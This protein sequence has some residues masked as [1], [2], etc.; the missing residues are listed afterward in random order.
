M[1][2]LLEV[3]LNDVLVG[4]LVLAAGDRIIFTFT[5]SYINDKN[6]PTLSQSFLN[7]HGDVIADVKSTHTKL[8]PFFSNLL[9]EGH[10]RK[11]LA[12]QGSVNPAREYKLIELLGDDLPGAVKIKP[13]D[14]IVNVTDKII[15]ND[16]NKHLFHFSLAGIQ[17]KFSALM[18]AAGG[19]TIPTSGVGGDWIVKLP[20]QNFPN[21]PEN[22]FSMLSLAQKT[23][24]NVPEFKL[25]NLKDVSGL[26]DL[27]VLAGQKALAIKRFDRVNG[28]RIHIEDFAQVYGLFPESKYEKAS[29]NNIAHVIWRLTGEAALKDFIRRLTFTVMIGNGDMHLKNWSLIYQDGRTAELAPA[30]DFVSTIPYIPNDKLA[31]T[32]GSTKDMSS[33]NM[34]EFEKLAKKAQVPKSI[35]VETAKETALTV[36]EAWESNK[37]AYPLSSEISE[38]INQ[39]ILDAFNGV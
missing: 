17:L 3:S 30:Y 14:G 34:L 12:E 4:K 7:Q 18:E 19:L 20:A 16:S 2:D 13:L 36:R 22:E 26:P 38:R 37:L 31:L 8:P 11:Y 35:V 39:Y 29:Y 21:V 23:G 5:E 15:N 9:P 27:G 6:R 25:V 1:S 24:I 32:L 28:Q 33:I 10:M